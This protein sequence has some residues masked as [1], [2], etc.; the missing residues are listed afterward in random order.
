MN[1]RNRSSERV[2]CTAVSNLSHLEPITKHQYIDWS[3][4]L[5][6]L[7][8]KHTVGSVVHVLSAWILSGSESFHLQFTQSWHYWLLSQRSES[9]HLDLFG[10]FSIR[11]TVINILLFFY[12]SI[13]YLFISFMCNSAYWNPRGLNDKFPHKTWWDAWQF[14]A[15]TEACWKKRRSNRSWG[16][17]SRDRE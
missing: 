7:L 9:L 17:V 16:S 14:Q 4:C 2:C 1:C 12:F 11:I 3:K 5:C 8:C 6:V 15:Q 10:W 13:M